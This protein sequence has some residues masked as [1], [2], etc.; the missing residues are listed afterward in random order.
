MKKKVFY[1]HHIVIIIL[2]L[3]LCGIFS[4]G[5][6]AIID[7]FV[8][9]KITRNWWNWLIILIIFIALIFLLYKILSIAKHRIVFDVYPGIGKA[10]E[11]KFN[12]RCQLAIRT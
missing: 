6:Y 9:G 4:S 3:G 8:S 7:S 12:I 1:Q 11:L 10:E 5:I 2:L